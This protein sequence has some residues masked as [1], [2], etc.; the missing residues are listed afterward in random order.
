MIAKDTVTELA[1]NHRVQASTGFSRAAQYIASKSKEFGLEHVEIERFPADGQK[2]YHTLRSTPG[3]EAASGELWEV[4]PNKTKVADYDEMRVALADYS[5]SADVRATL[6]DVGAGTSAKDYDGKDV[7]G[8]IVLAGGGVA[9][10]HKL[11]CDERGAA[12]ILSYQQNQVTGWSGD[13]VDNVRWGHLSPYNA[14]NKFAF[15]ISL[16]RARQYQRAT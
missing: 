7:K 15:M 2:T 5:R 3:W 12:G 16:R 13:Y 9:D 4:Q 14:D 6:V 8:R 11:A 1:R 10:V